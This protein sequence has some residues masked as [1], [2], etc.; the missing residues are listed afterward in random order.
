[1]KIVT[2]KADLRAARAS[3]PGRVAFVPT[4]GALHDGHIALADSA[5]ASCD[6]VITSIFVNPTQFGNASDLENYPSTMEADLARL[7]EAGTDLVFTPQAAE[8]YPDG[9]DTYVDTPRL[10]G[11]LMGALRPGHFRGVATVVSKLFNL[12]QPH[13]AW[14]GQKDYQQVA[15][16]RRMVED[17]DMGVKIIAHATIRE[18]DGLAMSGRNLRLSPQDRAAAPAL[19][20]ALQAARAAARHGTPPARILAGA[21]AMILAEPRATLRSLDLRCADTLDP[22]PM[23]RPLTR[24][25]VLLVAAE[26]GPVLLIDNMVLHPAA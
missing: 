26:F 9:A 7:Q 17:L 21:E 23:D 5:R 11:M 6:S 1:M 15:V 13:A 14:F 20:A 8:I 10:A 19:Y 2:T 12:T 3:L 24:N 25:A 18:T 4:M 16:I 22:L